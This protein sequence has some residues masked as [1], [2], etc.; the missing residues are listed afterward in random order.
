MWLR[1]SDIPVPER[2][3]AQI[4]TVVG[5]ALFGLILCEWRPWRLFTR[6]GFSSDFYDVQAQAFLRGK[7]EEWIPISSPSKLKSGPPESPPAIEQSV[8]I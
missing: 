8:T 4:V 5:T 1:S 2:R 6:A 3:A 7:L